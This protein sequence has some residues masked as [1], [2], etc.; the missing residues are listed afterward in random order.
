MKNAFPHQCPK[1]GI[2]SFIQNGVR[3]SLIP[4]LINYFQDREMTV[5]WHGVQSV[6]R[7]INGGGPQGATL[8]ILEYL[9]QSNTSADCVNPGDRFK[10]VD[11]LTILE[12]VNLLT[13]GLSSFNIKE[14]VP[15]DIPSHG[16]YIA[17]KDLKSQEWINKINDWT[18]GQKMIINENKTKTMIFNYTE[19]YQF[20][21]RLSLKGKGVEVI[22]KTKLLGTEITNDLK[23]DCNTAA[24]V[25]K[26]NARMEL[27]RRVASFGTPVEDL[28]TIYILF[29]RSHLEQSATVW[30]S[31]LTQDNRDD[32]ERVQK[33]ALKIILQEKYINYKNAL[34]HLNIESLEDRREEICLN[35]AKKCVKNN[36]LKSM[37]PLNDK[38]HP[39]EL[40]ENETYKVQFA[41]NE[42]LKKSSIIYM[43]RLLNQNEN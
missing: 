26:A 30:H 37:F 15:S 41:H 7:K 2:Q 3:P 35:F 38:N 36:K 11:D 4:L 32:L 19:K 16:Q 8:G 39:M 25:K 10:F 33:S 27:V 29:V 23:W 17:S 21:T 42:R 20:T 9:S 12:I 6:P 14:Q 24:I 1:L 34:N 5:K 28:K 43:Q 18:N 40:R 22:E 31:S 13:I